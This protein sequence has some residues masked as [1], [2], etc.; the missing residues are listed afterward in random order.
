MP[1]TQPPEWFERDPIPP[2]LGRAAVV[3]FCVMIAVIPLIRLSVELVTHQP[4]QEFDVLKQFPTLANLQ[5]YEHTLERSSAVVRTVRPYTQLLMTRLTRRGNEKVV[6]GRDGWLF[7][8]PSVQHVVG[9][10]FLRDNAK[11][12]P[13]DG[14]PAEAILDFRDQLAS[15][16]TD[17]LLLPLP[18]KETIC[19]RQLS[20]AY[21]SRGPADSADAERLLAEL[22]R[23]GVAVFDPA[24][25]LSRTASANGD[26]PFLPRD[27]HWTPEGM[28][29]VARELA[30]QL[31]RSVYLDG[32]PKTPYRLS[33][34]PVANRGDLYD[35]LDLPK[36]LSGVAPTRVSI[37]KVID[38]QRGK[39][40]AP[41][42]QSPLLLLG[43][44]FANIYSDPSLKW[45][46]AAGF[47]EHLAYHLQAGVDVIALNDGGVNG[48]R[49]QLARRP[50]M[51]V[52]KRLVIW[53]FSTRDFT[54]KA[55]EWKKIPVGLPR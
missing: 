25:L 28:D 50:A 40:F 29:L 32:A 19:P 47:A 21:R 27:T 35:M 17:L 22:E 23:A 30:A 34:E 39:P 20:A 18:S 31:R 8:R 15:H 5:A 14:S 55:G 51:L 13:T 38:G 12:R 10:G 37:Q 42:P 54:L 44:S 2:L 1:E 7:Y 4:V 36:R 53:Q 49:Q 6:I 43:D 3:V 11:G 9:P 26:L 33:E 16:D 41:D 52:G 45:G 24:L 46:E 48:C